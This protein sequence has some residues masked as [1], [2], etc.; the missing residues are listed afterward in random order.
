MCVRASICVCVSVCEYVCVVCVCV[1]ARVCVYLCECMCVHLI[2]LD[3]KKRV[4]PV[5]RFPKAVLRCQKRFLAIS[6]Y[7]RVTNAREQRKIIFKEQF[8]SCKSLPK[9][10]LLSFSPPPHFLSKLLDKNLRNF[11]A[12]ASLNSNFTIAKMKKIIYIL[13]KYLLKIEFRSS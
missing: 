7:M 6:T 13:K 5:I 8:E 4:K 10:T 11:F 9:C 1:C 3:W 2:V 12:S